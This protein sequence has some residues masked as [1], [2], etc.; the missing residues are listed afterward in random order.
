MNYRHF[1]DFE[2]GSKF[3]ELSGDQRRAIETQANIDVEAH[4]LSRFYKMAMQ[5]E[6]I[7]QDLFNMLCDEYS[8]KSELEIKKMVILDSKALYYYP[9]TKDRHE[10]YM[11]LAEE[12]A[13]RMDKRIMYETQQHFRDYSR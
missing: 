6:G 1:S 2:R 11:R 12:R 3:V 7:E 10:Y 8:N 5:K 4:K 13:E 9:L